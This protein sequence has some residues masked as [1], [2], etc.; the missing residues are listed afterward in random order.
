MENSEL[1]PAVKAIKVVRKE[2][3]S[4][5]FTVTGPTTPTGS[6]TPSQRS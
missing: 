4:R 5:S 3:R 2:G 6:T 1:N